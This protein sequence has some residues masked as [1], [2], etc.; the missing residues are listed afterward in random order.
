MALTVVDTSLHKASRLMNTEEM[1]LLL[2]NGANVNSQDINRYTP[3][4]FVAGSNNCSRFTEIA[5][6]IL[7]ERGANVNATNMF[8][9][10]PLKYVRFRR[11]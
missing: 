6:Q 2:D 9:S 8:G 11:K 3:L 1:K 5:C 10:T 4:H 7:L